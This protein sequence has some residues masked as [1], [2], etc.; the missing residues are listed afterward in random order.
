MKRFRSSMTVKNISL[1]ENMDFREPI[2]PKTF[3]GLW[4]GVF[5]CRRRE[6]T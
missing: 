4:F 6:M 3:R 1:P 2:K 5:S